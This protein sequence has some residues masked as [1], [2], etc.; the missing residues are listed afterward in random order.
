VGEAPCDNSI[1][2]GKL[3]GIDISQQRARLVTKEDFERFDMIIGL[4]DSNISNLLKLGCPQ[5]KL[6]KLGYYG[7]DNEDIPD[8]Y[9]FDGFDGF[10][11]IYDMIESCTI[12]LLNS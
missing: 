5:S 2:I 10:E 3:H 7:W 11:Q 6:K 1:K 12:K 4:D 8:P 9:F